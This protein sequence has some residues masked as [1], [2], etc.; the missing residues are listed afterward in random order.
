[1]CIIYVADGVFVSVLVV[2]VFSL[3]MDLV[4]QREVEMKLLHLLPVK[5]FHLGF[6]LLVLEV[7]DHV[8]K[9]HRK[10]VKTEIYHKKDKQLNSFLS[11]HQ[12]G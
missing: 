5:H 12:W 6:I 2:D 3:F 8:R 11:V 7:F 9:P 10:P 4:L 1:M